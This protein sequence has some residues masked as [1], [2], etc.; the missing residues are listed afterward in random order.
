M[1]DNK[2]KILLLVIVSVWIFGFFHPVLFPSSPVTILLNPFVN[3]FYSTVCHQETHKLCSLNEH[4]SYLCF[5]CSGIY[6][7]LFCG[8]LIS[9]FISKALKL[10]FLILTALILFADVL[11][12]TIEIYDYSTHLAFLTGLFFGVT[13]FLYIQDVILKVFT[14]RN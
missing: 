8:I 12:S 6:F 2:I 11:A 5:R 14:K 13:L 4:S 9:F 1:S 7:G 3:K 10:K